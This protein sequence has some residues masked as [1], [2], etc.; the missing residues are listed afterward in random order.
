MVT[1][2]EH[3]S[4]GANLRELRLFSLEKVSGRPYGTFWCLKGPASMLERHCVLFKLEEDKSIL[5]RGAGEVLEQVAH[6]SCGRH[7]PGSIE[8]LGW[9]GL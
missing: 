9:M 5:D 4:Y 3:P 2:M 8:R 7:I 1:G 6:R